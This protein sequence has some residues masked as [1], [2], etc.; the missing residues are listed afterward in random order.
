MERRIETIR[1]LMDLVM[2][3]E[4]PEIIIYARMHTVRTHGGS[5]QSHARKIIMKALR[6]DYP[7]EAYACKYG[8]GVLIFRG[9][10]ECYAYIVRYTQSWRDGMNTAAINLT[11]VSPHYAIN[12]MRENTEW[13]EKYMDTLGDYR[14]ML[15]KKV[16][17]MGALSTK[18]FPMMTRLLAVRHKNGRIAVYEQSTDRYSFRK[19]AGKELVSKINIM[20]EEEQN[21]PGE[22][23]LTCGFTEEVTGEIMKQTAKELMHG[24]W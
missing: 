2:G 20:L 7:L 6:E 9:R 1:E 14:S 4:R 11:R 23:R 5:G 22:A 19:I 10:F 18:L 8:D 24:H 12:Y 13:S 17:C 16:I 21:K 3:G 15:E